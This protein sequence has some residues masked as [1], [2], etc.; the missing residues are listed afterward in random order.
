MKPGLGFSCSR[1]F[2]MRSIMNCWPASACGSQ[3]KEGPADFS[4][5]RPVLLVGRPVE[6]TVPTFIAVSLEPPEPK[7]IRQWFVGFLVGVIRKQ[8][9]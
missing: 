6:I 9:R 2:A 3:P 1:M 8:C 4:M 5:D 7:R